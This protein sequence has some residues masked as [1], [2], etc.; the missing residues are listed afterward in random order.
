[1]IAPQIAEYETL[2]DKA[3]GVSKT[4]Q[5]GNSMRDLFDH[6]CQSPLKQTGRPPQVTRG[7][8]ASVERF[9]RV[10]GDLSVKDITK[11]HIRKFYA[12]NEAELPNSPSSRVKHRDHIKA[13]LSLAVSDGW[14]DDNPADNIRMNVGLPKLADGNDKDG[15]KP[16]SPAQLQM[17]LEAARRQWAAEGLLALKILIYAGLRSNECAQLRSDDIATVDGIHCL[18]IRSGRGQSVK[19]KPSRRLRVTPKTHA[20]CPSSRA[21]T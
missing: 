15:K 10:C 17:L 11:A 9:I 7:H 3:D 20:S 5:I 18:R 2:I 14:R 21:R 1:M 19:N 6:W 13:L 8:K 4:R 12:A 16:F